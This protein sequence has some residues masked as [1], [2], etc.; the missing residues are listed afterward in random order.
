MRLNS[1]GSVTALT[2]TISLGTAVF[3]SL[4][5]I[6]PVTRSD[7]P[8]LGS[9]FVGIMMACVLGVQVFTPGLVRRLS[10]RGLLQISAT[11]LGL[12]AMITGWAPN[13]ATLLI[14]GIAAGAAFG[15]LIVAGSQGVAL[16]VTP[17]KLGRAL[18][19]YGLF[20]MSSSAIGSPLGVQLA[21]SYSPTV[22]GACSLLAA[23]AAVACSFGIPAAAG[24]PGPDEQSPTAQGLPSPTAPDPVHPA[25]AH[26]QRPRKLRTMAAT[27]PWAALIFLLF[28]VILLSHGLS[29][30]PVLAS[31]T[32]S[33]SVVI[34]VVQTG[35]AIGRSLGGQLEAKLGTRPTALVGMVLLAAGGA[36]GVLA[37]GTASALV[38][39]ACIGLGV[40]IV[41]TVTLHAAMLRM[42]S[43]SASVV[44]N[45]GVD[46]GLWTGGILWG[47]AL[48]L[49]ATLP[50]ALVISAAVLVSG[51]VWRPR[52]A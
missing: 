21:L 52:E 15:T 26:S 4:Y 32:G 45:L 5:S 51:L 3:F 46:G 17:D 6:I 49:D 41:Q 22:F 16:L 18:G 47:L 11:L 36:L 31:P 29:S 23:L 14:G 42:D 25:A 50:V 7:D 44:W 13:T 12:G 39:G 43:G 40:G 37:P 2:A 33:A 20:T 48:S 38:A 8:S 1:R 28:S 9:L 34:F 27:A 19:T 10:L 24:R 30:L 35:N